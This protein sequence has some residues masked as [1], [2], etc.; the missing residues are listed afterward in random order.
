LTH[1]V[2]SIRQKPLLTEEQV[3]RYDELQGRGMG[4]GKSSNKMGC[5]GAHHHGR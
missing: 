4:S 3:R 5:S 2:A 1:L